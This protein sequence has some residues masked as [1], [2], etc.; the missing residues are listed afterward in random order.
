MPT[1]KSPA[2]LYAER[3]KRLR[4]AIELRVP[5]RVPIVLTTNYFPARYVG[6]GVDGS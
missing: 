6:G 5:D 2:E 1:A 4:D 3:E